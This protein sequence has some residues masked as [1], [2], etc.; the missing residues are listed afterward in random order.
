MDDE[1]GTAVERRRLL[2]AFTNLVSREA[3]LPPVVSAHDH[4]QALGVVM[5]ML[6]R[7][8]PSAYVDARA[9]VD[10]VADR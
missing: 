1:P 5:T 9:L 6:Q 7:R 3:H 10:R 2:I 4:D 8:H